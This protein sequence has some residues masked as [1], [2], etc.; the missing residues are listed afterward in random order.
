MWTSVTSSFAALLLV[1]VKSVFI[2]PREYLN[3]YGIIP[4]KAHYLNILFILACA[5]IPSPDD[6]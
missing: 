2:H 5:Y 4:S 1:V 3:S 6:L